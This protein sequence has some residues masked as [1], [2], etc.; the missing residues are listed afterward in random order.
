MTPPSTLLDL[1]FLAALTDV[2]DEGHHDAVIT[3]REL[4]AAYERGEVRLRARHDHLELICRTDPTMRRHLLAPVERI[5]VARQYRRAAHRLD[6]PAALTLVVM[7]RE[8]IRYLTRTP[9][10]CQSQP[11]E[12]VETD[13]VAG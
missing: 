13:K 8:R 6:V 10:L 4:V 3:Y 1:S 7:H 11:A 12:A 5:S 9:E 2:H